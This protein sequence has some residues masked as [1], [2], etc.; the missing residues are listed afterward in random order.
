M[1]QSNS[2]RLGFPALIT[3]LCIARGVVS[4]SL[5]FESL[6][7]T[8]NLAYI[9]KNCSNLDDPIITFPGTRKASARG[10]SEASTTAP[11]S[12]P[13]STSAPPT[14]IPPPSIP[15]PAGTSAQS[16]DL[17]VSML[18]S[19]HHGL[20]MVMQSIHD[21]A[22]H[23]PIISMEDFIAQV[24]WP[25]VQP[26]FLG[27]GEAFAAQEATPETTLRTSPV[28]TP[29][30]EVSEEEDGAADTDYVVGMATA[31]STSDP[32]PTI[33]QDTPQPAQDSPSSPLDEPTMTQD[34]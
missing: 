4:D 28:T 8:I 1:A 13:T 10:P 14:S 19:L 33:A 15:A 22:Q 29:G 2:Y 9:K 27:R 18:K 31:Q 17:M 24:V 3:T 5:T 6:S 23:Q 7:P 20:C 32:W 21:L 25:G 26:S 11:S 34:E 30:V 12:A 16:S